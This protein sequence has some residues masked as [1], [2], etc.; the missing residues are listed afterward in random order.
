MRAKIVRGLIVSSLLMP[1]LAAAQDSYQ[2]LEAPRD[3]QALAWAK[4]QSDKAKAEIAA[5][6]GHAEIE[7][8]LKSVLAASDPPPQFELLGPIAL[9]FQKS[10]AHPHGILSVARRSRTGVPGPWREVL[11]VDA[12]R[13]AEAKPYELQLS[14]LADSCLPPAYER[15][16]LSLSPAG[17]DDVELREFDLEK[18]AFVTDGFRVPASR[19]YAVWMSRDQL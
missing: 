9:K 14:Q 6:P 3:P 12:L 1:S 18:G 2:W 7:A 16:M 13:K 11:D 19:N 8:E 15:C 17:S 10:V 5:M 4:Q